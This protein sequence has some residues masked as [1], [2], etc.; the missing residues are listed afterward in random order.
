MKK[1]LLLSLFLSSAVSA[2][3]I[4]YVALTGTP[5]G[6]SMPKTY[7]GNVDSMWTYGVLG[8]PSMVG[9]DYVYSAQKRDASGTGAIA[10]FG[11]VGASQVWPFQVSAAFSGSSA[12]TSAVTLNAN[13]VGPGA[14]VRFL[15][16][17]ISVN[18]TGS[19]LIATP[20]DSFIVT[21]V[22]TTMDET[23]DTSAAACQY[24][25]NTTTG[26]YSNLVASF[27]TPT[28]NHVTA[29]TLAAARPAYFLTTTPIYFRVTTAG[30]GAAQHVSVAITGYYK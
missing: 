18:D 6:K 28:S 7:T 2:Q 9:S 20:A 24:G 25:S 30:A 12:T 1:I 11:P 17:H 15:V 13:S 27:N 23:S 16:T 3:S 14:M 26:L 19:T 5:S 10:T 8:S 22:T 21:S 4:K 29:N